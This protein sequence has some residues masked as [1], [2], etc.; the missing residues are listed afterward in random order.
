MQEHP[1]AHERDP[2]LACPS[3]E[4]AGSGSCPP[5][6]FPVPL[7]L[8]LQGQVDR[9]VQGLGP[10]G[11]GPTGSPGSDS[12]QP[13]FHAWGKPKQG[14][15][16]ETSL[17]LLGR[18]NR[19]GSSGLGK[20]KPLLSGS[21]LEGVPQ[22]ERVFAPLGPRSLKMAQIKSSP[23]PAD[24]REHVVLF[25]LFKPGPHFKVI[26]STTRNPRPR[27]CPSGA[28]ESCPEPGAQF[29]TSKGKLW[30]WKSGERQSSQMALLLLPR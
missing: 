11:T 15:T 9:A 24:V 20:Q 12:V 27:P 7:E 25:T 22:A 28:G 2:A 10:R 18:Q 8:L 23:F 19:T 17:G 14:T 3:L 30:G 21:K 26:P 29:C 13:S 5:W 4:V 16:V 1:Y 6:R